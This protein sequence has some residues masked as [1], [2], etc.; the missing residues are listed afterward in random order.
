MNHLPQHPTFVASITQTKMAPKNAPLSS[1]E[2]EELI[3]LFTSLGLA[4]KTASELA[5][6]P[7]SATPFKALIDKY[8]LAGKELSEKQAGALVKLSSSGGKLGSAE[9]GYAVEKIVKS[10]IKAPDQVTGEL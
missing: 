6:Q 10:D 3:I 5:R 8:D 2:S 1:A 4:P 7:K 9:K